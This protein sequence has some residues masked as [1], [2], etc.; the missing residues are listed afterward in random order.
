[1]RAQVVLVF[2]VVSLVPLVT[3]TARTTVGR[4][5]LTWAL[6]QAVLEVIE[7][8]HARGVLWVKT[9]DESVEGIVA[10]HQRPDVET[11]DPT[12][13]HS[14]TGAKHRDRVTS[15]S[16][17]SVQ[18]FPFWRQDLTGFH[19]FRHLRLN[20]PLVTCFEQ[21]ISGKNLSGLVISGIAAECL[22]REWSR[23]D[24]H[25]QDWPFPSSARR[26]NDDG[27]CEDRHSGKSCGARNEHI[28]CVGRVVVK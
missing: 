18:Q 27:W 2:V 6:Q 7:G 20:L 12:L 13:D 16:S 24:E 22:S 1:M 10:H 8:T 17:P 21:Q 26:E 14:Q 15:Q 25:Y 28:A 19:N 4:A 5:R 23:E 3:T 9:T 11:G